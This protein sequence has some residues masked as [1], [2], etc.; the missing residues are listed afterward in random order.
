MQDKT[1]VTFESNEPAP[2]FTLSDLDG[3]PVKLSDSN[4]KARV[5]YFYYANCPD[6]CPPTTFLMSELQNE[7]KAD[8][9]FGKDVE[10]ISITFDPVRDTPDAIRSFIDKIPNEIDQTGWKF[11]RGDDEQATAKLMT[12]FGMMVV[13]DP[14]TGLYSHSDLI[15]FIDRDGNIRK[16]VR[17]SMDE[18]VSADKL[19]EITDAL[20]DL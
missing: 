16:Y 10:F 17:G 11:L 9:T 6:V 20:I 18:L 8:G 7:L 5:V 4:G 1:T 12:D 2:E 3:N 19:K 13:K 14:E 15:T